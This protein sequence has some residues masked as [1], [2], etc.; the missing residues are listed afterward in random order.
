M[1]RGKYITDQLAA[2]IND[3]RKKGYS[4]KSIQS[5]LGIG[6]ATVSRY[7]DKDSIAKGASFDRNLN[8]QDEVILAYLKGVSPAEIVHSTKYTRR[9]IDTT[10]KVF[11]EYKNGIFD[12]NINKGKM[13]SRDK[14]NTI[15]REYLN[16]TPI[17]KIANST[18][19]SSVTVKKY[20][21]RYL[22]LFASNKKNTAI[23]EVSEEPPKEKEAVMEKPAVVNEQKIE[24][25]KDSPRSAIAIDLGEGQR[26]EVRGDVE[27]FISILDKLKS[28]DASIQDITNIG[29]YLTETDISIYTMEEVLC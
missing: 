22:L 10:I 8:M 6:S 21:S 13:I 14:Y 25:V 24:E 11:E 18:D 20:V 28:G 17:V 16:G 26:I 12:T 27:E 15:I 7:T 1:S 3:L 23:T 2:E 4:V 29:K 19:L 9:F 5:L